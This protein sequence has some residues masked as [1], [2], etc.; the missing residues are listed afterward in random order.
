MARII[1][2]FKGREID[3]LKVAKIKKIA[4]NRYTKQIYDSSYWS[5][6]N[7]DN[8]AFIYDI[9][10]DDIIVTLGEDW[11]LCYTI[12]N[13]MVTFLEWIAVYN[14]NYKII[15]SIEMMNTLKKVLVRYKEKCFKTSMRHDSSYQFYSSML[16]RNYFEENSHTFDIDN[17]AGFAPERLKYLV[18]DYPSFEAFLNSTE[19]ME[20][21]E[22][23][24]YILHDLEFSVTNKLLDKC[25]KLERNAKLR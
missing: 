18:D 2:T 17:C 12:S 8:L 1:E 3:K 23:L 11:L 5:V 19:A 20:H 15:Q 4:A 14:K 7:L 10:V 13:D 6:E 25:A 22:Y 24:K 21:P 16:Q 9:N